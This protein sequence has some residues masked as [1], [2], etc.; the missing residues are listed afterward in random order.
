MISKTAMRVTSAAAL[1]SVG[2]VFGLQPSYAEES[3]WSVKFTVN[4]SICAGKPSIITFKNGKISGEIEALSIG[5]IAKIKGTVDDDGNIKGKITRLN[6][7]FEGKV[8][9]NSG[10]GTWKGALGCKGKMTFRKL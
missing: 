3:K 7:R 10:S 9:G 1:M 4:K 6:G 2:L 8:K 5:A